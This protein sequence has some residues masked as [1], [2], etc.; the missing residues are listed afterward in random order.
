M[1]G[2]VLIGV[3]LDG[4]GQQRITRAE[5]TVIIGGSKKT[6]ER[7]QEVAIL[8]DERCRSVGKSLSQMEERQ[9]HDIICAA[10]ENT[11]D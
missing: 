11:G 6:H 8:V 5:N 10:M 3:G 1:G 4:D 9:A 7:M 2:R